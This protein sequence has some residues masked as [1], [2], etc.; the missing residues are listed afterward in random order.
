MCIDRNITADHCGRRHPRDRRLCRRFIDG[1]GQIAQP[2]RHAGGFSHS[3][4]GY[5]CGRLGCRN[6]FHLDGLQRFSFYGL[7]ATEIH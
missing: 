5:E 6:E 3:V 4:D 7:A 1:A 2:A